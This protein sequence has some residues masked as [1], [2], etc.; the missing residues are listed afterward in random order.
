[1]KINSIHTSTALAS[2]FIAFAIMLIGVPVVIPPAGTIIIQ[3]AQAQQQ[4]QQT[5]EEAPTEATENMPDGPSETLAAADDPTQKEGG[6]D[7]APNAGKELDTVTV[8][9]DV[10]PSQMTEEVTV[11]E[12]QFLEET[13]PESELS[14][15][16]C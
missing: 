10:P 5:R 4:E 1:M 8:C 14:Y 11:G 9:I 13:I 12:A 15:G 16:A 7:V 6:D 2:F 3:E